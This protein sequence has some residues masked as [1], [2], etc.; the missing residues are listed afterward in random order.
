MPTIAPAAPS[1]GMAPAAVMPASGAA[2]GRFRLVT[3]R[4]KPGARSLRMLKKIQVVQL[5]K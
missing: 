2:A 4:D 3:P 5:I 1:S